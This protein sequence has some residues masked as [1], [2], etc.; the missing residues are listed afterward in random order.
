M[1]EIMRQIA[2]SRQVISIT[3]LPQVASKGEYHYLVYKEDTSQRTETH[4]RELTTQEH[5]T[6]VEKMREI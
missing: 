2:A 4:I 3:H 6:E 5:E 1:G